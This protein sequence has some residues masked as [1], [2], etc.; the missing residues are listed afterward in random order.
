MEAQ[1]EKLL[2]EVRASGA[3]VGTIPGTVELVGTVKA[4]TSITASIIAP[5]LIN[6]PT[7][8]GPYTIYPEVTRQDFNTMDKRMTKDLAIMEIPYHEVSNEHGETVIIG[9]RT[10]GI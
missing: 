9:G 4:K 1:F 8:T 6:L 7:Y 10:N 2:G 3:V 5:T